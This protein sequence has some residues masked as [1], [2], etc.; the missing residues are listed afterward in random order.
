[1]P[2]IT[3]GTP[4]RRVIQAVYQRPTSSS[5]RHF[6]CNFRTLWTLANNGSLHVPPTN[7]TTMRSYSSANGADNGAQSA[8]HENAPRVCILGGGFGGLYTAVKLENLLWPRGT[9]PK[10]TLIDKADRFTFKPLLYELLSGAANETEVAPHF[11]DL[12]RPYPGVTFVQ[13]SVA[14]VQVE[15]PTEKGGSIG[16]GTVLLADGQS[17]PYD[18]LILSLGSKT[19]TFGIPG[20]K[21]KAYNFNT[22]KDAVRLREALDH[23]KLQSIAP[24]VIVVGGGYAGVEVAAVIAEELKTIGKVS[25]LTADEDILTRS[26]SGQRDAAMKALEEI[27]VSVQSKLQV[28]EILDGDEALGKILV[29]TDPLTKESRRVAADL[30]V[31]S[32]GQTPTPTAEKDSLTLPFPTTSRGALQTEPTLQVLGHERVFALG[33]VAMSSNNKNKISEPLPATA[34]VAFQQADYVAWNVWAG[35]NKKPLLNFSYQHLGELMSLGSLNGA[36][37]IPIPVPPPLAAL[38]SSA[39]PLGQLLSAAGVKI[40]PSL[41]GGGEGITLEGPLAAGVRRAA[42]LYR[43]PTDEQRLKVMASWAENAAKEASDIVSR[44]LASGSPPKK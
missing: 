33:D 5:N 3:H 38:A 12:L 26:P 43:Q 25:I 44:V 32:A 2:T 15:T 21:D 6:C 11:L 22:Y 39:G 4:I 9:R 23:I 42:Y 40:A 10:V 18:W 30:I 31:W 8:V 28:K 35:L 20:V 27:G 41:G 17:V 24:T 37:S 34:Q 19:S 29:V 16:G 7:F 13:G 14:S 36:A 1:M